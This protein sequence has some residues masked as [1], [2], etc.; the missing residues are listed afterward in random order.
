MAPKNVNDEK[1]M[2]LQMHLFLPALNCHLM[3]SRIYIMEL[4][5]FLQDVHFG[6]MLQ[7]VIFYKN[8]LGTA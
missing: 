5:Y 3:L 6:R 8:C 2:L 4:S 7:N 1:L